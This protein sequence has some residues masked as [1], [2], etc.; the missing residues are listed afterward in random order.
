[1][2]IAEIF[3][4][5]FER[6]TTLAEWGRFSI[7]WL[8]ISVV[9]TLIGA[10]AVVVAMMFVK[11]KSASSLTQVISYVRAGLI[12]ILCCFMVYATYRNAVNKNRKKR[13]EELAMYKEIAAYYREKNA[14][15]GTEG[16]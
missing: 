16:R 5:T 7:R 6:P 3:D 14:E 4:A 10:V 8:I 11:D 12:L 9:L 13:E 1:M 15:V 2:T